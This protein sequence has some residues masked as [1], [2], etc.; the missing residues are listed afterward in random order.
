M[1]IRL[2]I[3]EYSTKRG[4]QIDM[5]H[6]DDVLNVQYD[7]L[8]TR[9]LETVACSAVTWEQE[10][11]Y[12]VCDQMTILPSLS[13]GNNAGSYVWSNSRSSL[14]SIFG[15]RL[16]LFRISHTDRQ[17]SLSKP[18]GSSI[19]H[20]SRLTPSPMRRSSHSHCSF[21]SH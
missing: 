11:E 8:E 7:C 19:S 17:F 10:L 1:T 5:I 9:A 13:S 20:I 2:T 18:I 16:Y 3:A 15:I 14:C 21:R 12:R 6:I 4:S